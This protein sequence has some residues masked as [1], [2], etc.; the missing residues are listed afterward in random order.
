MNII[1]N[2]LAFYN[3]SPENDIYRD[4]IIQ[5]LDHLEDIHNERNAT[6]YQMANLCYVSPS[7]ISR[8]S[9]K[10]G[11]ENYI[12]FREKLLYV[13]D[14]YDEFNRI[15]PSHCLLPDTN[16]TSIFLDT[17]EESVREFRS[18]DP[19]IYETLADVLYNG[20]LIGLFVVR[21][22]SSINT[23]ENTLVISGKKIRPYNRRN[24]SQNINQF[25][26]GSVVIFIYPYFKQNED[27]SK[28]LKQCHDNG[29]TT[30][31]ITG[32]APE[33]LGQY[34]DYFFNFKGHS[35]VV[36]NYKFSIFLNMITMSYRKKYID[37]KKK[38]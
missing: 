25:Q 2:L 23:L 21:N 33:E 5:I 14:N 15:L 19:A 1:D 4:A 38:Q 32:Q 24:L 18:M 16:D 3:A 31:L 8:L 35:T 11:C 13:M 22:P 28:T 17:L 12:A 20:D 26:K 27:Y 10:L 36:D 7:T 30:I 9:R 34:T 29:A 37:N 6:I